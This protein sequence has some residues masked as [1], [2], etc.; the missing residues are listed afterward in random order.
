MAQWGKNDA[1]SNSTIFAAG[2]LKVA[3]NA[4]NRDAL[5][6][7]TTAD[8]FTTGQT[9]GQFG[10]SDDEVSAKQGAVTHSG[11]V[12]ETKGSGGRSGRI[13]RETLV[14][15]GITG[16]AEDTSFADY[17]LRITTQPSATSANTT[18]AEN[19]TFTVVSDSVPSGASLTY[20]W[21][22][23][24]GDAIQTGGNV[25]VTTTASLVVNSAVETANIDVK[26]TVSATG[27]A[28]IVSSNATLTI[29]T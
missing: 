19:A 15:G 27:A 1:A 13:M 6:G 21:T 10:V 9:I 25:G 4:A 12:L 20:A 7:N 22:Y 5:F 24:N 28:N 8:A 14:A 17:L 11:W 3:A 26:V 29:T 2:G 18:A 23:A 16:D